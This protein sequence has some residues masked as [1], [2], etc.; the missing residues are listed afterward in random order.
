MVMLHRSRAGT[1]PGSPK[2][3]NPDLALHVHNVLR[4]SSQGVQINEWGHLLSDLKCFPFCRLHSLMRVVG[5]KGESEYHLYSSSNSKHNYSINAH[6]IGLTQLKVLINSFADPRLN[7]RVTPAF[8][9]YSD[10]NNCY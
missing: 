5:G 2:I 7:E 3:D 8:V 9:P 1:A 4:T 10:H 6:D